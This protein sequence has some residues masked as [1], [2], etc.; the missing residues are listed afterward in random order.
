MK[1]TLLADPKDPSHPIMQGDT[2]IAL[3][4]NKRQEALKLTGKQVQYDFEQVCT[5]LLEILTDDYNKTH[6]KKK[7]RTEV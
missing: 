7:K 4:F 6:T 1:I 5:V 2:P 3:E